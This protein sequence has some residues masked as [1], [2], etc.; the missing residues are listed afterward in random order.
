LKGDVERY[1]KESA[2]VQSFVGK[3]FIREALKGIYPRHLLPQPPPTVAPLPNFY[4]KDHSDQISLKDALMW[5]NSSDPSD[6]VILMDGKEY[7]VE[8]IPNIVDNRIESIT[9]RDAV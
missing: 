1:E 4:M 6:N 8:L 5:N 9:V 3:P 2:R 7:K